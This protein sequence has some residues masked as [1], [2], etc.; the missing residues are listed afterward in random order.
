MKITPLDIEK[1]QF[2]RSLRGYSV[3][4]VDTFLDLVAREYEEALRENIE[5][6][7]ELKRKTAQVDEFRT[8]EEALKE[9]MVTAQKATAEIKD[10]AR[11]EADII[12]ARAE[13]QAE[14]VI[15]NAHDRMVKILDDIN[16]LKRQRAQWIAHIEGLIEA[17]KK[18]LDIQK[19]D[20]QLA[21]DNGANVRYLGPKQAERAAEA[22]APTMEETKKA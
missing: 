8:R 5:V 21:R 14:K 20:S 6:K 7:D 19:T 11:K 1:Q 4:E 18:L 13:F 2:R 15:A 12:M 17:H 3:N 16:E 10:A 9:T 22:S